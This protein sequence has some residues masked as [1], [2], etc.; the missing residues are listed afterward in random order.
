VLVIVDVLSFTTAV[1]VAVARG[2]RVYPYRH[3]D[4][5]AA[6]F[7][8]RMRATL[9]V[10]RQRVSVE[11]PYSLSPASRA[12]I[13][14]RDKPRVAIPERL[15]HLSSGG[16]VRATHTGWLPTERGR[17]GS[18][19]TST[20]LKRSALSPLASGGVT[21]ACDRP[22]KT[23]SVP[24]DWTDSIHP[25][26]G[27]P[28]RRRGLRA[29]ERGNGRD[30][31]RRIVVGFMAASGDSA[32]AQ[33]TAAL[34]G[35][36]VLQGVFAALMIPQDFGL[37]RD[38]FGDEFGRAFLTLGPV[39]GLAT[40]L[41]PVVAGLLIDANLLG[42]GWCMI[43]L[44][45]S[46]TW[47]IRADRR[48]EGA[49]SD[50]ADSPWTATRRARCVPGCDRTARRRGAGAGCFHL[51]SAAALPIRRYSAHRNERVHQALLHI[52][53]AVRTGVLRRSGRVFAGSGM[54]LQMGLR[55]TPLAA[56]LAM[57]AWAIGAFLGTAFSSNMTNKLGRNILHLGLGLMGGGLAGLYIAFATAGAGL[58]SWNFVVPLL[59]F[60]IGMGMIFARLFDI[61]LGGLEDYEVGTASGLLESFQSLGASLGIAVL[62]TVLFNGIGAQADV[63]DFVDSAMRVTLL[64]IGLTALTFLSGFLLPKRRRARHVVV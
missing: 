7:A 13:P 43:F 12:G 39:I 33:A 4:D 20:W 32:T 58:T 37:I 5:S 51:V 9:A 55:Y 1:E 10:D 25:I 47:G 15:G 52:G 30:R 40:I 21:A 59:L 54:F 42:A 49:A 50:T 56:S 18:C 53:R 41:G 26:Y 19:G 31:E 28:F 3:R 27:R 45:Q 23:S 44:I 35:A 48:M 6:A 11:Q 24:V 16:A 38:L 60:G 29:E 36:R 17:C 22:M 2:A 62:G 57:S 63:H 61:V 46:V 8:Q 64:T 14:S 34:I